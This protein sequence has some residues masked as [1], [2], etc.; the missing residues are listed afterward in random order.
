L[1]F[2]GRALAIDLRQCFALSLHPDVAVPAEHLAAH[3]AGN[4]HDRLVAGA[5]LRQLRDQ[6][7]PVIVA[8][9]TDASTRQY[10]R[11]G[12]ERLCR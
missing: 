3:V 11:S 5:G 10:D 1:R 4:L 9:T 6:R 8:A 7:V 12:Q 2:V